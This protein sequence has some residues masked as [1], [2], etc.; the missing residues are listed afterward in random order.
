MSDEQV[1]LE[2]GCLSLPE[3]FAEVK[4]PSAIRLR[5]LDQ[6]GEP[7]ELAADGMLARCLLHEIDHLDGTLFIDRLS[8]LKREMYAKRVKKA[9]REGRPIGAARS[10]S[11]ES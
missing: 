7:Q 4:R 8:R 9:L 2:E 10:A 5:Y 3:Q 1:V 6:D 11:G